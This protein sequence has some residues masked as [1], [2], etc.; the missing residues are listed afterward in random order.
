MAGAVLEGRYRVDSL[1]ASGGMST[2]YAG[3]DLR[4]DRPVAIKVLDPK[5]TGN[6]TFLRRFE[7]EARTA[8][9]LHHPN[10]VAVHDQGIDRDTVYLVMELVDG[11][12][13]RDLLEAQ[14]PLEPALALS[15]ADPVA[16][17]LAAAH[18]AGLVHRDVKPENVLIGSDSTVKVADFGLVRALS[19]SQA[20]G[21]SSGNVIL[22]TVAYLAPEQV[23]TGDADP[24]S[25]VYALGVLLFEILTGTQPYTGDT[26]L[27]V[28]Y[29]HVH[30]DMPGPGERMPDLPP[31]LDNL[32]L[33]ATRRD[34]AARPQ[35][36]QALRESI[37]RVRGG[38]GLPPVAVP[39]AQPRPDEADTVRMDPARPTA[40]PS[41]TRAFTRAGPASEPSQ[42][43][44]PAEP[45]AAAA[46]PKQPDASVDLDHRYRRERRRSRRLLVLAILGILLLGAAIGA[47]AWWFGSGRWTA[48][49]SV[50]G[51][52]QVEAQRSIA[53]AH[54]S[55]HTT[56]RPH[57]KVPA[58]KVIRSHP[59]AGTEALREDDVE[60]LVS[61]GKPKVP[62]IAP[63]TARHE[64]ERSIRKAGMHPKHEAARDRYSGS[65]DRGAVLGAHPAS[66][67]AVPTGAEVTLVL[68]KGP[69]PVRVPD[70]TGKPRSEAFNAL[71]DAGLK[72][73]KLPGTFSGSVDGG[74]VVRTDPKPGATVPGTGDHRVGVV[75]STGVT[76]PSVTGKQVGRARSRLQHLGL[77]VHVR[78][79]LPRNDSRVL[80]QSV[81]GDSNVRKGTDITLNA[82]P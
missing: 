74:S 52:N 39:S 6:T 53:E 19:G 10:I 65:V 55:S 31:A 4:L 68:S 54:L 72:P 14:A 57:D 56:E 58:G 48:V 66:G 75:V 81:P 43:D 1:L 2:V 49:P 79:L 67:T 22:G 15:V 70:V 51:K 23:E 76:V 17:A 9:R 27:S 25:D 5:L 62:S 77:R 16:A 59:G 44:V 7:L 36:A 37:Q 11:G 8:A 46:T 64:A 47:T 60:L 26:A 42:H 82:L 63:G 28:A 34:P 41:G 3:L 35:D 71:R 24:R 18:R 61:T 20:A 21:L 12:T 40:G 33:Q 32:V 73:H 80:T 29:R 30:E 45:A 50:T 13:L 38:L 69:P 78:Q